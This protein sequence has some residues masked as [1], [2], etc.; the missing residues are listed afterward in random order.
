MSLQM[1]LNSMN[2]SSSPTEKTTSSYK[3]QTRE[4]E[5]GQRRINEAVP[6]SSGISIELLLTSVEPERA[7]KRSLTTSNPANLPCDSRFSFRSQS[8]SSTSSLLTPSSSASSPRC[9]P[10]AI[11]VETDT[12]IQAPEVSWQPHSVQ[13]PSFSEG[14]PEAMA[15]W[16]PKPS[17][18]HRGF[19]TS[20]PYHHCLKSSQRLYRHQHI[21]LSSCSPLYSHFSPILSPVFDYQT[22]EGQ[23]R[24]QRRSRNN[25]QAL[26]TPRGSLSSESS[27][28]SR[29][30]KARRNSRGV[31]RGRNS[32]KAYTREQVHWYVSLSR[33]LFYT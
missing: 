28:G 20:D 5:F 4:H 6:T 8:S 11:E 2:P 17:C 30:G 22:A 10:E 16:S 9:M 7:L 21:P 24:Q 13:L 27:L 18:Q 31:K 3:T 26:I 29:V 1:Q 19:Q 25:L 33:R 32:N 12:M 23:R 14:F 15:C